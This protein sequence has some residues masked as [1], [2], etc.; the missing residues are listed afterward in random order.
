MLACSFHTVSGISGIWHLVLASGV[1]WQVAFFSFVADFPIDSG[2]PAAADVNGVP[3]VH[4]WPSCILLLASLPFRA[5]MHLLASLLLLVAVVTAV[6][7][8]PANAGIS[9][10]SVVHLVPDVL[11]FD[12]PVIAAIPHVVGVT[13]VAFLPNVAGLAVAS[14][15]ADPGP[16]IFSW[17]F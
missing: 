5:S 4:S 7:C 1:H 15:P 16:P 10:A 6:A 12:G 11:T 17:C 9:D 14:V 13:A 2:G 3:T 8:I